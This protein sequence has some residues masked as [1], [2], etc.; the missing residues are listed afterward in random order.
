MASPDFYRSTT[1]KKENLWEMRSI[2]QKRTMIFFGVLILLASLLSG[3]AIY[4]HNKGEVRSAMEQS[5]VEQP[6]RTGDNTAGTT[7]SATHAKLEDGITAIALA[8]VVVLVL[9]MLFLSIKVIT[10]LHRLEELTRR[11]AD[12][13]LDLLVQDNQKTSCYVDT[14]G[15]NV[16]SLAMNLQEVL[17]LFWNLSEHNIGTVEKT[18]GMVEDKDSAFQDQIKANLEQMKS[19]LQQMQMLTQQFELFDVTLEGKK[20]RAKEDSANS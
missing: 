10:P 5:A 3:L 16:N 1:G 7:G 15:E 12:G 14:I 6:S 18:I 8:I 17:L 11:M 20:A 2:L 13:R 19:E 4:H 9:F